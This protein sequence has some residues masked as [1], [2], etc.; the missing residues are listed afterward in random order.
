MQFVFK[1]ALQMSRL[2]LLLLTI[3]S[4]ID[5]SGRDT[6]LYGDCDASSVIMYS[7]DYVQVHYLK[8]VGIVCC[9]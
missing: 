3:S 1:G 6:A 7:I 9:C 2:T 4:S 5:S 8:T